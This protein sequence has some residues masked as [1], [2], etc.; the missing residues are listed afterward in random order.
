MATDLAMKENAKK[1]DLITEDIV[2][3]EF[4]DFMDLFSEE[5]AN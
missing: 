3:P 4:H 5:K 2:P 1:N